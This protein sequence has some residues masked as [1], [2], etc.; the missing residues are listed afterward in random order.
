MNRYTFVVAMLVLGACGKKTDKQGEAPPATPSKVT[1]KAGSAVADVKDKAGAAVAK[2]EDKVDQ[3]KAV[4]A[5]ADKVALTAEAYEALVVGLVDCKIVEYNIDSKC[6]GLLTLREGLKNS[7]TGLRDMAGMN[8]AVGKK[9]LGHAAAPVR[10]YSV[11]LMGGL[12]GTEASSQDAIVEAAAKETDLGVLQNMIRTVANS[13][14][15][16]PKVAELL[17]KSADHANTAVRLQAVYA[18]SSGWNQEMPGGP[19]KLAAMVAGDADPK[20]RKSACEYAGGLGATS[21]VAMYEKFTASAE[22]ADLYSACMNGLVALFHN[23]PLYDTSVEGAY[24][25]FLKRI[26]QKPRSEAAP[27]WQAMGAFRYANTGDKNSKLVDWQKKATWFKPA[28]VKKALASVIADKQ[29][30][31]MSR[32]GAVESMAG[33]GATKKEL[34]ALKASYDGTGRTDE[35]VIKKIDEAVAKMP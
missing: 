9:L 22:D 32:T 6:P 1:D 7:S 11:G 10:L 4:V 2:I 27:P 12:M 25:L 30:N 21:L 24:K 16:N 5:G 3:A 18:I 13:G 15:K 35:Y 14:A 33:L 29:S 34:E 31:W 28:D 17:L 26:N 8:A 20:V 19:D 23:Y